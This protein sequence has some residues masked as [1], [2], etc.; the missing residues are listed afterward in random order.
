MPYCPGPECAIL[1]VS[2]RRR[3]VILTKG[4]R[5]MGYMISQL[6]Y[7]QCKDLIGENTVVVLPIGGG[8]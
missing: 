5:I 2:A 6:T 4:A 8:S 3:T 7:E 1:S